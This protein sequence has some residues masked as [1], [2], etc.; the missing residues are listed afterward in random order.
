MLQSRRQGPPGQQHQ[1]SFSRAA[2]KSQ[3]D[4]KRRLA[5]AQN[6]WDSI[7]PEQRQQLLTVPLQDLQQRAKQLPQLLPHNCPGA[8]SCAWQEVP[9]QLLKV[10]VERL[11][12]DS[13]PQR[14]HFQQQEFATREDFHGAI[15]ESHLRVSPQV[16]QAAA[17]ERSKV[18]SHSSSSSSSSTNTAMPINSSCR[19]MPIHHNGSAVGVGGSGGTP[20]STSSTCGLGDAEEEAQIAAMAQRLDMRLQGQPVAVELAEQARAALLDRTRTL[21]HSLEERIRVAIDKHRDNR[22]RLGPSSSRAA[23]GTGGL[24]R[25]EHAGLLDDAYHIIDHLA[26]EHPALQQVLLEPVK[27]YTWLHL[28]VSRC[29]GCCCDD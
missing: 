25:A 28:P 12:A 9:A 19:S 24:T 14:W 13:N 20:S 1:R 11:R 16:E 26:R 21:C 2:E 5:L 7:S 10:S 6:L 27:E 15:W 29:S 17:N 4:M 22:V 23:A 8:A 3:A 18:A